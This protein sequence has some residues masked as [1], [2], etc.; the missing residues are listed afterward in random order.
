M[1]EGFWIWYVGVASDAD[2][3]RG[4]PVLLLQVEHDYWWLEGRG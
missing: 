4:R 3:Y 2:G 1:D